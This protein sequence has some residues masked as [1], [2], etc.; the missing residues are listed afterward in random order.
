MTSF[1]KFLLPTLLC[2]VLLLPVASV[3]QDKAEQR[4]VEEYSCKDIMRETGPQRGMATA[5]LHGFFLGKSG[6]SSFNL[7][8]LTKQTDA[9]I[10]LCLDNPKEKAIS[11]MKKAKS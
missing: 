5:F 11:I 3:A 9:F 8:V 4:T 7:E 2:G 10:N 1:S 6:N